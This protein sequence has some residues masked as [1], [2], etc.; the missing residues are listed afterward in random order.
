MNILARL[1]NAPE[2]NEFIGTSTIGS[3]EAIML[4]LLAHKWNWKQK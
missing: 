4:A 2:E 1:Y 3:S